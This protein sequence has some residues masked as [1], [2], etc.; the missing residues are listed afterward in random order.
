MTRETGRANRPWVVVAFLCL[1][2]LILAIDDG[3][4]NLALPAISKEFQASVGEL[5][6]AINAYLLAFVALLL[7]M[8]TLGDRFGRKRMF[9][10][11]V[12]LFGVSSLAAALSSRP[13][14]PTADGMF[15]LALANHFAESIDSVSP[16]NA[17]MVRS[18]AAS[19]AKMKCVSVTVNPDGGISGALGPLAPAARNGRKRD[20]SIE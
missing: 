1:S 10:V 5:Q 4:L 15:A 7:T 11:G 9:Q 6:W 20:R 17:R 19:L 13:A 8:G 16:P 14:S 12:I 2:V 3:V 18:T